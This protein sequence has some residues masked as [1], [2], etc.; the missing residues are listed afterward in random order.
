M[1]LLVVILS[2]DLD[3]RKSP[4]MRL[5][6]ILMGKKSRGGPTEAASHVALLIGTG[7]E[8]HKLSRLKFEGLEDRNRPL[9]WT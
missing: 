2:G 1:P 9:I 6:I 5:L 7:R 4:K 8:E 3:K